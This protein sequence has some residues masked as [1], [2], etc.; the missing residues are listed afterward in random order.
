MT[1][2]GELDRRIQLQAAAIVNDPD[3]NTP[4]PNWATYATVWAAQEFHGSTEGEASARQYAE[5]GL[6]FTIRWRAD[7]KPEHRL[8]YRNGEGVEEIYEIVGRPREIG[9]R[10]YL[11][12]Q[13][14]LVE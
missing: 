6:F 8:L 4:K 13:A 12:L 9:R 3:Y 11:K 5:Y 14:R 7:V 2:A 10:R 1:G